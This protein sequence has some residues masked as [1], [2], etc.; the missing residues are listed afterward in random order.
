MSLSNDYRSKELFF[1]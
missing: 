1:L